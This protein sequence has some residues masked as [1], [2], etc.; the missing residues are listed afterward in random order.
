MELVALTSV[1]GM[2][3]IDQR[4]EPRDSSYLGDQDAYSSLYEKIVT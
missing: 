1:Y 3:H 2:S 4:R